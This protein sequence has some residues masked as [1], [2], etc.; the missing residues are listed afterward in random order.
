LEPGEQPVRESR[1]NPLNSWLLL[2]AVVCVLLLS[3]V[4]W[5]TRYALDYVPGGGPQ[6]AETV[7]L[8]VVLYWLVWQVIG[9]FHWMALR[10]RGIGQWWQRIGVSLAPSAALLTA[11]AFTNLRGPAVGGGLSVLLLLGASQLWAIRRL[12]RG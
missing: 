2:W 10:R 6:G 7:L 12:D 9:T 11:L 5:F 1:E 3:P 4:L 8:L